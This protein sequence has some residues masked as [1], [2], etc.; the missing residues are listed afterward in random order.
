MITLPTAEAERA[1]GMAPE[2][3]RQIE[4]RAHALWEAAGQPSGRDVEFWLQAE[5]DLAPQESIAGEEDPLA[6][7]DQEPRLG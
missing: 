4:Q 1:A 6:G 3:R 7:I 5:R 2:L